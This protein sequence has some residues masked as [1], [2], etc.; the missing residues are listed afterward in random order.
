MTNVRI[1]DI[2]K[3]QQGTNPNKAESDEGGEGNG[4]VY[5]FDRCRCCG[6]GTGT[7]RK[8]QVCFRFYLYNWRRVVSAGVQFSV[9]LESVIFVDSV[10]I[11][12]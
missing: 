4:T 3:S 6:Y 7:L 8:K 12:G 5:F 10:A 2:I 1:R 11:D 9:G